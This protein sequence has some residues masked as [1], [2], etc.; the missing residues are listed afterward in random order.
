[1]IFGRNRRMD[2][3]L[4]GRAEAGDV[5]GLVAALRDDPK[6]RATYD[7]G[8][9]VM[10]TLERASVAAVELDWVERW[11]EADGTLT[12]AAPIAAQSRW[13]WI[14]GAVLAAGAAVVA[15]RPVSPGITDLDDPLR[16]KGVNAGPQAG[17]LGLSVLCDGGHGPTALVDIAS[18]TC[19][20][21]A[22]VGFALRVD[23][24][25]HGGDHLALFGVDGD[26]GVQYYLP[27]PDQPSITLTGRDAWVSLDRAVRLAVNHP[28]GRVRVYAA[29]LPHAP[30]IEAIEQAAATLARMPDVGDDERPWLDRLGPGHAL[31]ADCVFGRCLGAELEFRIEAP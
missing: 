11:L 15:L 3:A 29:L 30:R 6:L 22:S 7:R 23:A 1:M 27:T 9:Q 16:A 26:G 14:A 12:G 28:P 13:W 25:H 19:P 24:R 17:W 5:R 2:R 18:A 8:A 4:C 21:D 31:F 10:R 20:A